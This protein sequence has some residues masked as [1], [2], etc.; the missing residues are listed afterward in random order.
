M[1][2]PKFYIGIDSGVH[3]GFAVWNS[4]GKKFYEIKTLSFWSCIERLY[5]YIELS[6][7][8]TIELQA[9][10][11]DVTQNKPVFN[12]GK[13]SENQYR[14]I[15]QNVGQNK[16]DCQLIAEYL[17]RHKIVVHKIKPDKKSMTKLKADEFLRLTGYDLRTSSHARDAAMLVFGR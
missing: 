11:E 9:Y 16:R 6:R 7:N 14:K 15:A 8:N 5:K 12:K 4:Y 17:E 1:P 2:I 3:T 10:I 13:W